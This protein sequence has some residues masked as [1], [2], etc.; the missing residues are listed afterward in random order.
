MELSDSVLVSYQTV[1][2]TYESWE[3]ST[4]DYVYNE[5]GLRK[6]MLGSTSTLRR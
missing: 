6:L 4:F 3:G 2:T 5:Q 1:H